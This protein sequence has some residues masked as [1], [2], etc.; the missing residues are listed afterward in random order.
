[1]LLASAALLAWFV[2]LRPPAVPSEADG[3][4]WL[5]GF[6]DQ[7]GSSRLLGAKRP[8]VMAL[9]PGL[10][11]EAAPGCVTTW[12]R[13]DPSAPIVVRQR[14]ELGRF[15]N[16]ACDD[17][18]FG[19]LTTTLRQSE[20]VTPGALVQRLT[21]AFGPPA[22]SR[23]TS[24]DGSI[25]TMWL[26]LDGV[27]VRL[28]EP[29]GPRAAGTFSVL[30]TRFYAAPTTLPTTAEGVKWMDGTVDLLTGPALAHAHGPATAAMVGADMQ[31]TPFSDDGCQTDF[32]VD[33][34]TK[35]P[36][37]SGQM[38]ALHHAEGQPCDEAGFAALSMMVW[39][40]GPVTAEA[41]VS[42]FSDRLG[43]PVVTRT[44]DPDRIDY[45]WRTKYGITVDLL[46][47]LTG[48]WRHW[49]KL[50]ASNPRTDAGCF[51]ARWGAA[52][53]CAGCSSEAAIA[54]KP[55]TPAKDALCPP[56]SPV[57]CCSSRWCW[58]S[59]PCR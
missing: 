36:I 9:F 16:D 19:M 49:L 55:V 13:N 26:I 32:T 1:M 15:G 57:P 12:S 8:D 47:G 37:G 29:V 10:E 20:G 45:Q 34:L 3:K 51:P 50:R 7:I 33:L 42:R 11:P 39:R 4:A 58:C 31:A 56:C 46:E 41:L 18:Q 2:L 54:W 17:A 48:D 22:I 6:A 40:R 25:S 24:L 27:F 38:L 53:A 28:R 35:G 52:A 23:D 14:L 43:S 30:Y 5:T 21:E 59:S 44:F